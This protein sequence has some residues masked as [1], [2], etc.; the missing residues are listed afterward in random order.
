MTHVPQP[1]QPQDDPWK[2]LGSF[3]LS[4]ET[5]LQRER[6]LRGLEKLKEQ[7]NVN[8]LYEAALMLTQLVYSQK[9]AI[10]YLAKEA[11]NNLIS[12]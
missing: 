5:E 12:N 4:L 7:Q 10:G 3:E 2:K 6:L 9:A 1:N 11:A 8:D